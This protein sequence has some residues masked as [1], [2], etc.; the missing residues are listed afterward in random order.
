[1]NSEYTYPGTTVLKNLPGIQDQERLDRFERGRTALRLAELKLN[2]IEGDFDLEHLKKIHRYIFQDVYPFAGEIRKTNIGKNGFWF[3]EFRSIEWIAGNVFNNLNEDKLSMTLSAEGFSQKAA[4]Y[5]SEINYI[6][7]F[8]E[9]NGRAIREFFRLLAQKSGFDLQWSAVTKEEYLRAVLKT[10]EPS[11]LKDLEKVMM[12]C[13]SSQDTGDSHEWIYP[14]KDISLK[15][16]L[17]KLDGLPDLKS[18]SN[19]DTKM[20]NTNVLKY[21]TQE[22]NGKEILQF[23]LKDEKRSVQSVSLSRVP[24]LSKETKNQLLDQ[25]VTLDRYIK[26]DNDMGLG[27]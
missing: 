17:K 24:Y 15:D 19:I 27:G 2:P 26:L 14:K 3:A 7:P 13:I 5:Y 12:K 4:R 9:G 11:E 22:N 18:G 6:H 10:D 23:A 21:R 1:M 16:I 8:R 20:L 25:A